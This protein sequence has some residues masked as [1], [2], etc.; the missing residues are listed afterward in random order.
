MKGPDGRVMDAIISP[1]N[2]FAGAEHD[3]FGKHVGYT[4]VWNLMDF[5]GVTLPITT[6]SK[7]LDQKENHLPA[8]YYDKNDKQ[9]WDDYDA[10][11]SHGIPA[12]LQLIGRRLEEEKLLAV[13]S[14]LDDLI[15]PSNREQ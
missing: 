6:T 13:A 2:P 11:R 9:I 3:H 10:E 1:A 12:G 5:P 14:V 4:G 7:D 8:S 15:Q